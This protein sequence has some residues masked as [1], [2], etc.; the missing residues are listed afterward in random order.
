MPKPPA[1][2]PTFAP[3]IARTRITPPPP[4]HVPKTHR[5]DRQTDR[6]SAGDQVNSRRCCVAGWGGARQYGVRSRL[7]AAHNRRSTTRDVAPVGRPTYH[8]PDELSVLSTCPIASARTTAKIKNFNNR[9][10]R[11]DRFSS[12]VFNYVSSFD[13][14]RIRGFFFFLE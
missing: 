5:N 12:P 8:R 10:I 14:R 1:D 3:L 11:S 9:Y 13:V 4:P 2:H 6:R 7:V